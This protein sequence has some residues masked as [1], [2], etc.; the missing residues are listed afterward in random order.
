MKH[1][2]ALK[3]AMEFNKKHNLPMDK[4]AKVIATYTKSSKYHNKL[5]TFRIM[6]PTLNGFN[7][8]KNNDNSNKKAKKFKAG[9]ADI[10]K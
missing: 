3:L 6:Y 9:I 2:D 4:G 7:H 10:R 8:Q 1:D 5:G